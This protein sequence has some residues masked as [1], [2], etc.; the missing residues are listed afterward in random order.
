MSI[1]ETGCWDV[2]LDWI[3]VSGVNKW[4]HLL[5]GLVTISL[6]RERSAGFEPPGGGRFELRGP[7]PG[8]NK[9]DG[10]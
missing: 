5:S 2:F 3:V 8:I 6:Q 1:K 9:L 10:K 7:L 4:A